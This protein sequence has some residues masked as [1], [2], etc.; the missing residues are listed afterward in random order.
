[1][2]VVNNRNTYKRFSYLGTPV[3]M[4]Q[5]KTGEW[6]P[7]NGKFVK[8]DNGKFLVRLLVADTDPK[9]DV[10]NAYVHHCG[11]SPSTFNTD[12]VTTFY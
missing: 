8:T 1:M 5:A 3:I 12:L 10:H 11:T 7:L 9:P 4:R 6:T 2:R